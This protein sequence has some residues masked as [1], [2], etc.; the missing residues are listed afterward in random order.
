MTMPN[1]IWIVPALDYIWTAPEVN[2]IWTVPDSESDWDDS[3]DLDC[4]IDSDTC[5][6]DSD[7]EDTCIGDWDDS[8]DCI[9]CDFMHVADDLDNAQADIIRLGREKSDLNSKASSLGLN[10]QTAQSTIEK[11]NQDNLNLIN[12]N[13]DQSQ[14][15]TTL[16]ETI[17]EQKNYLN[18]AWDYPV[19]QYTGIDL[20]LFGFWIS[21]RFNP[22]TM[23]PK[24]KFGCI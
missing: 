22:L 9:Y 15:N 21:L 6:C 13:N 5:N 7:S 14:R 17:A 16:L 8:C 23:Y 24:I 10:L 4:C 20:N 19:S 11:L 1:D 3:T 2:Y 18:Q 12:G